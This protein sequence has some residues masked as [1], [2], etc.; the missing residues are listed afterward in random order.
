[1][2]DLYRYDTLFLKKGVFFSGGL[3]GTGECF[4]EDK[5]CDILAN[6]FIVL[7]V[8]KAKLANKFYQFPDFFILLL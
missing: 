5:L 1:M 7:N 2:L 6:H 3:S 4:E 8:E